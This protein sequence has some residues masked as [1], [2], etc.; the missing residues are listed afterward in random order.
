M[1]KLIIAAELSGKSISELRTLYR[2]VLQELLRSQ[3]GSAQRRN[4][5]ASLENISR[6]MAVAMVAEPVVP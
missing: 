3:P 6:A 5:L 4:A 1:S 2:A